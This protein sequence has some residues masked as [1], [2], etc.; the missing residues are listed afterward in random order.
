MP[1]FRALRHAALFA[2]VLAV[3]CGGNP[4][5]QV[6]KAAPPAQTP[7][8]VVQP[9]AAPSA[10]DP[11]AA[12]IATSNRHYEA[13]EK[14]LSQGHLDKARIEF[15][16]ALDV[17]LES[18]YGARSDARLREHF[19][20]LVDKISAREVTALS[21]G[22][23][24]V[25][26]PSEPASIDELLAVA[27]FERFATPAPETSAAVKSD[28]RNTAHDVPIPTNERVLTYIELFQGRLREFL[29]SG[30]ERGAKY[31]PMIQSV[32]RAEGL[33]LDL[34]YVPL[35][36]SAFKP[37]ALSTAKARGMWQFMRGT[38]L[39]NGLKHDWYIDERADPEKATLAAAKYLKTLHKIFD[40]DWHLALASYNGGPGRVQRAV[41]RSGIEDF[42]SLTESS[43]HLPRETREY[44]PMILA[45]IVIAK[46]PAQYG[47]AVTSAAPLGYEK[48]TLPRAM[49][50]RRVAEWTETPINE[51]Q[52]L[53]PELRRW[54]TPVRNASYEVK[55]PVGSGD[56]LRERLATA[57]PGELAPLNWYR[58][59][60]GESLATIAR[61]L[62]VSRTDLAEANALTT[63]SRVRAGQELIIPRAPATLLN[64]RVDRPA[65]ANA[66]SA[67]ASTGKAGA[68]SKASA[69]DSDERTAAPSGARRASASSAA[70][71]DAGE[72]ARVVYRVKR[73]DTLFSIARAFEVTVDALRSWNRLRGSHIS[74]GDRLTI[75]TKNSQRNAQ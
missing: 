24:F 20:R 38:A 60:K 65:P 72:D 9:P 58:V 17:L 41:K 32:F 53:N 56:R 18:P 19:D 75:Q 39:E 69:A 11:I 66:V 67:D 7:R 31:L 48:V 51:I 44:V 59:K 8:P 27:T 55:V 21:A 63:K 36:E 43:K 22:D 30:L 25:E 62:S 61:K 12:L 34:A 52:A 26:K 33:P 2:S 64:A 42:W 46:N 50:L 1:D 14:E 68:E 10:T 16:Q 47:F 15:N 54:T 5:P 40:G 6:A 71:A 74:P 3:G 13:G 70:V 35:I 28:L 49:D 29:G 23:G 73:G 4:K 37:T 45:A 57:K